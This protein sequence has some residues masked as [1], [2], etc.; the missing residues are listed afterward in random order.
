MADATVSVATFGRTALLGN[1]S[2]AL[3]TVVG[4]TTAYATATGGYPFDLTSVLAQISPPSA[5]IRPED[6]VTVIPTGLS[7]TKY[8]VGGFVKGTAT[9]TTG[10][11]ATVRIPYTLATFPCTI[12]FYQS[13]TGAPAALVEVPDTNYSETFTFLLII[14]R[15]G[16]N[17]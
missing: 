10:T 14:A 15:G 8:I 16:S 9:W 6:V 12:R 5:P 4:D 2:A 17:V 1:V 7:S 3:V 13:T 11:G